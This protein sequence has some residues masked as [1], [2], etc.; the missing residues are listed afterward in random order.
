MLKVS[1]FYSRIYNAAPVSCKNI[2]GSIYSYF[3]NTYKY[4]GIYERYREFLKETQYYSNEKLR[5]IQEKK[6]SDILKYANNNSRYYN[7]LIR[8]YD[9]HLTGSDIFE[10]IKKLPILTKDIV[11]ENYNDIRTNIPT[12]KKLTFSSSGTTGTSIHIPV[13]REALEREY[14]YKWQYQSVADA[15]FKDKFAYF[16][17]HY[18]VPVNVKKPPF[19]I[20][21]YHEHSIRFSIYHLSENN[22]ESYVNAFNKFS[23]KY[24][25]GYPSAFYTFVRLAK[26]KHLEIKPVKAIF[27]ASEVL[28]DYQKNLVE[29]YLN[30]TI[31]KWYGQVELTVNLHECEKRKMHVKEEY[32]YLEL[33]KSDGG[34]AEPE[35]QGNVI[36]TGFGNKAFPLIR[37][38]TGDVMKLA[39]EQKCECGRGGRIIEEVKG[40]DEDIIITPTGNYVGR[41]DFI[42]KPIDNVK[43]SQIIQEDLYNIRILVVSADDFS[44]EDEELIIAKTKER[45]GD[46]MKIT[47]EKT[48]SIPRNKNGKIRY[49]ISKINK[50]KVL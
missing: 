8:K 39:K 47:V 4:G 15:M 50:N 20:M 26:E 43:E 45:L 7:H 41:L 10:E 37:Y 48:D 29:E 34:C 22:I 14:A 33:I 21:D 40:R 18:V 30:T 35:E 17:G 6:L 38:Y 24:I 27:S 42:F 23:P 36:G 31:Y 19:W 1:E 44:K 49:V 9:V 16:T 28:H 11:R 25:T 32:G 5:E 2:I 12:S 3:S 13:T 46:E